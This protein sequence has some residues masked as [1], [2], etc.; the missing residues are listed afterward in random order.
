MFHTKLIE[1]QIFLFKNT[2]FQ[3]YKIKFSLCRKFLNGNLFL[4]FPFQFL[5]LQPVHRHM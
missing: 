3:I 2:V 5:P 4:E 1:L